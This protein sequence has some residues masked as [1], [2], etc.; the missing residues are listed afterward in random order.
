[1]IIY[2]NDDR[3]Y[4]S[5]ATHHR[6]GFVL[7]GRHRPRLGH[8][9]LHRATCEDIKRRES[10]QSH[11]TNGGRFKACSLEREELQQWAAKQGTALTLCE[12]CRPK[13]EAIRDRTHSTGLTKLA[14][15][16]LDYIV[17]AAVIHFEH[18]HPPYRLCVDDIS[19]C[20]AK[21]PGQLSSA[22][23]QLVDEGW[24]EVQGRI[25]KDAPFGPKVLVF[26]TVAALRTLAGFCDDSDDILQAE[27]QKLH[28][29]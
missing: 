20:F 16:L 11:W 10:K 7:E 6:R 21:T 26:P 12:K 25:A 14:R 13:D 17:E 27:L 8:L 4:I 5:W 15:E 18:E 24:A 1:M 3:P 28:A 19:A 2:I 23:Y 29:A 22:L 9:I